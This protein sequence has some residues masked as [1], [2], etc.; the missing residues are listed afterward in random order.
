MRSLL[1]S[2][3]SKLHIWVQSLGWENPLEEG[4]ATHSSVLACRIPWTEEPGRLQCFGGAKSQTWPSDSYIIHHLFHSFPFVNS[5]YQQLLGHEGTL[6]ARQVPVRRHTSLVRGCL[7]SDIPHWITA[8]F[9]LAL[10][11]FPGWMPPC[12]EVLKWSP[13]QDSAQACP[14]QVYIPRS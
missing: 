11:G 4:M 13:H 9:T 12:W 1:T 10:D 8:K 2:S 5:V 14:A 6:G 7:P 3:V